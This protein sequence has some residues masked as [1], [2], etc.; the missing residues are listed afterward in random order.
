MSFGASWISANTSRISSSTARIAS[1]G[2]SRRD[3][4]TRRRLASSAWAV[5]YGLRPRRRRSE[6]V[7]FGRDIGSDRIDRL[8]ALVRGGQ[9][10]RHSFG[11]HDATR[12]PVVLLSVDRHL[13]QGS[14]S[15]LHSP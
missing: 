5:P 9:A 8:P 14:F 6:S 13:P 15:S 3:A 12:Q 2:S 11:H 1:G 7:G 10:P 4:R